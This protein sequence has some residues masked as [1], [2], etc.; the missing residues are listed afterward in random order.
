MEWSAAMAQQLRSARDRLGWSRLTLAAKAGVSERTIVDLETNR[1][2]G[3]P[4]QSL[5]PRKG[6]VIRIAA[7]LGDG[8]LA[9]LAGVPYG[10]DGLSPAPEALF[11][12]GEQ[13]TP[14]QRARVQ[15]YIDAL[16]E[17]NRA[18]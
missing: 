10:E 8:E 17:E 1:R 5:R 6:T 16:L 15:G 18:D 12:R 13:L 3:Q 9:T 7:A 11:R 4:D 2:S 14:E